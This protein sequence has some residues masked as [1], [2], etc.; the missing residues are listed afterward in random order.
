MRMAK[1]KTTDFRPPPGAGAQSPLERQGATRGGS[2][3]TSDAEARNADAWAAGYSQK[4]LQAI[5]SD[6]S[7]DYAHDRR[8]PLQRW[9]MARKAAV[10]R[11][12]SALEK[13]TP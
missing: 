6:L 13:N 8:D 1:F 3:A 5:A 9:K 4:T 10:L 12:L 11:R 7:A 2:V